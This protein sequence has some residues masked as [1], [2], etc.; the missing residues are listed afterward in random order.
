MNEVRLAK[1]ETL[2]SDI[3]NMIKRRLFLPHKTEHTELRLIFDY[4]ECNEYAKKIIESAEI[5]L[6]F[7]YQ[8]E[9]EKWKAIKNSLTSKV[10][11]KSRIDAAK[12]FIRACRESNNRDECYKFIFWSLMIL[13]V[14]KNKADEYLSLICDF[15][16]MLKITDDEFEDIIHIIKI[17]YNEIDKDYIFKTEKIKTVFFYIFKNYG[18]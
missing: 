9:R 8:S 11:I 15:A 12:F 7:D 3:N 17:I 10:D 16:K 14:D 13:T 4:N 18:I 1:Y 5:I 6:F 2:I